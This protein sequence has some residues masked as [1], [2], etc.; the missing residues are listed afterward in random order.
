[1][2]CSTILTI[3][4]HP[5]VYTLIGLLPAECCCGRQGNKR[6]A[7]ANAVA[8]L[9]TVGNVVLENN[10]QGIWWAELNWSAGRI[11]PADRILATLTLSLNI[12]N[13]QT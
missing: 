5:F 12:F 3:K 2:Y 1:M 8:L 6:Q 9:S 11:R 7:G 4:S 10:V 13:K